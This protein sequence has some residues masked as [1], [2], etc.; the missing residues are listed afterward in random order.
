MQ[1][2]RNGINKNGLIL[3]TTL[4]PIDPENLQMQKTMAEFQ[5]EETE[6]IFDQTFDKIEKEK[7]RNKADKP[8]V[9][10]G[11]NILVYD[12]LIATKDSNSQHLVQQE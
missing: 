4:Q 11:E 7:D 10:D 8:I 6:T 1:R 5:K 2:N 12:V 3:D 9:D